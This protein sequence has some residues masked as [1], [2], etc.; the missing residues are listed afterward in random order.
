[1]LCRPDSTLAEV[2]GLLVAHK[3]HRVY[4]IDDKEQPAGIVTMTDVL[5]TL[6][7]PL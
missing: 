3:I 7:A 2:V 5:R 1:M 6:A 4:V